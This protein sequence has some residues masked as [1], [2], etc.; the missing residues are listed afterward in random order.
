M[1]TIRQNT[2]IFSNTN[3]IKR[4][5]L[6]DI[7]NNMVVE[8]YIMKIG[9]SIYIFFLMFMKIRINVLYF[10]SHIGLLIIP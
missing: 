1:D 5:I 8:D 4:S 2:F 10:M 3:N 7:S 9:N 6:Y